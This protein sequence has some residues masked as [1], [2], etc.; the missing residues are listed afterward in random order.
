M[1]S[2]D[3]FKKNKVKKFIKYFK[4]NKLLN[5]LQ[6]KPLLKNQKKIM[7]LKKKLHLFSIW[8]SIYP[9]SSIAVRRK[10]FSKFLKH[11][12]KNDYPNLEIDSRLV[13]YAFL[14]KDLKLLN[15]S[16]T[17]YN[18]DQFGI[19]SKYKKFS[20]NWWVKRKEAFDYMVYL[21]KKLKLKV[22]KGPDF[23]FTQL[24]NLFY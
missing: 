5:I 22:N 23:Y 3:E 11:V 16:L 17:I 20:K 2:D 24:I 6:D 1:D 7:K 14:N 21:M 4:R 12:K 15:E 18:L 13:I 9:T 19:S 10:Y 8:P